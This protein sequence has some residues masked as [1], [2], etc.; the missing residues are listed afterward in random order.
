MLFLWCATKTEKIIA[1]GGEGG[2]AL[3]SYRD[4]AILLVC[5]QV[6]ENNSCRRG[7]RSFV[8]SSR[9]FLLCYQ[10]RENNSLQCFAFDSNTCCDLL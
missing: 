10:V 3:V 9:Y 5:Y 1:V 7:G 6:G 4:P 8:S 2:T